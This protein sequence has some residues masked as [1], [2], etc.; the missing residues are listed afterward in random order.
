MLVTGA[1]SFP[2]KHADVFW[3]LAPIP[4]L[5]GSNTFITTCPNGR[6]VKRAHWR[7]S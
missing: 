4:A 6:G 7:I 5:T 2:E 1:L 3:R